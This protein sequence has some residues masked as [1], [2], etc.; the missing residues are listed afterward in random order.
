M[1]GTLSDERWGLKFSVVAGHN[2]LRFFETSPFTS[3]S[4]SHVTTDGQSVCRGVEPTLGLLSEGCCC[5]LVSV[6][7]QYLP[8]RI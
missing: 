2:C 1:W 5:C 7:R 3:R 6:G 8:N 4:R